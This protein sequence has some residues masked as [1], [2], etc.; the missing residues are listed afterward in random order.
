MRIQSMGNFAFILDLIFP[1]NCVGC[2]E[3][4]TILCEKCLFSVEFLDSKDPRKKD[5]ILS[6]C[7]YNSP[8]LA[9]IVH[10]LKYKGIKRLAEPCASLIYEFLN[11]GNIKFD[12]SWIITAVPMHEYKLKVRGFNQS[13][14]IAKEL[15]S[16][17]NLDY[18]PLLEK[19]RHT[20]PQISLDKRA[21]KSNLDGCFKIAEG[22]IVKGKKILVID[23]V[24]STGS[25]M[26]ECLKTLR[27]EGTSEVWGLTLCL[28]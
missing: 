28:N 18:E 27:E 9:R 22:R 25:T 17:M 16:F 19:V 7:D 23:D 1:D 4:G 21:R 2:K 20:A 5:G 13:E 26:S 12:N 14:L 15:A 3:P 6:A 8:L 11:K 10:E 24:V